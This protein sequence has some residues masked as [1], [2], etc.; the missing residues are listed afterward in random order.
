MGFSDQSIVLKKPSHNVSLAFFDPEQLGS[1]W[2]GREQGILVT[3]AGERWVG[4][5]SGRLRSR[6]QSQW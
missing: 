3:E 6:H 5:W 2:T 4:Q 1:W